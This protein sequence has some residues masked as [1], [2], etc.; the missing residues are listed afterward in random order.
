MRSQ[1]S[2]RWCGDEARE[3]AVLLCEMFLDSR[4]NHTVSTALKILLLQRCS[5]RLP[6][7]AVC[8]G[9]QTGT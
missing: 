5:E 8:M 2:A 7:D 1:G 4:E 9:S 6:H 3:G